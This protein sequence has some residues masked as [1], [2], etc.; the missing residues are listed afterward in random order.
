MPKGVPKTKTLFLHPLHNR[1][2]GNILRSLC[3]IYRSWRHQKQQYVVFADTVED[4]MLF[5]VFV[6]GGRGVGRSSDDAFLLRLDF[7]HR[8]RRK[9]RPLKLV[10]Q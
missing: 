9:D 2:W 1:F 6:S 4:F 3:F 10:S 7:S 5:T 8:P